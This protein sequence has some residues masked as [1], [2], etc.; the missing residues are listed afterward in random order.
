MEE[1]EKQIIEV[2]DKIKPFLQ[3]DGG[4]LEY[5]GFNDGI[6]KIKMHGACA[7]CAFIDDTISN[8]VEMLLQEEVP[9][10]VKVEVVE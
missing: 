4:D 8:G 5:I 3:K 9:G 10:V 1:I 2:L 7:G 6:V